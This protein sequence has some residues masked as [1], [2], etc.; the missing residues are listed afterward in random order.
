MIN[1]RDIDA[2]LMLILMITVLGLLV[3]SIYWMIT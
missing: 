3:T 2:L 1:Q